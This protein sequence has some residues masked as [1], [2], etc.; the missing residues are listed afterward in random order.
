MPHP[1]LVPV[2]PSTSRMTQSSG[3]SP[4]TSTLRRS[5]L[6][7]K[8]YAMELLLAVDLGSFATM[9]CSRRPEQSI[10]YR[11][12]SGAAESVRTV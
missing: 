5:P 2:I 7:L 3:V 12:L 4:S 6:I 11:E 10:R 1:Y 9:R 8:S